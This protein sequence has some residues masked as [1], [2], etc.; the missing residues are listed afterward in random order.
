MSSEPILAESSVPRS[1]SILK[2]DLK[3]VQNFGPNGVKKVVV[4]FKREEDM[5]LLCLSNFLHDFVHDYNLSSMH[6]RVIKGDSYGLLQSLNIG[7]NNPV[8][9]IFQ[10]ESGSYG[11]PELY[12]D[13]KFEDVPAE[14]YSKS[15][16]YL[17]Y[18]NENAMEIPIQH[19]GKDVNAIRMKPE[20]LQIDGDGEQ[21][22]DDAIMTMED[23]SKKF[24]LKSDID[25]PLKTE[26][27]IA[28][29]IEEY[30]ESLT[31]PLNAAFTS[32]KIYLS[33]TSKFLGN[34]DFLGFYSSLNTFVVTYLGS[35][36]GEESPE[37]LSILNPELDVKSEEMR[38]LVM[39]NSILCS[40][41]CIASDLK[42]SSLNPGDIAME[43]SFFSEIFAILRLAFVSVFNKTNKEL[44]LDSLT[45]LNSD[46]VTQQFIIYYMLFLNCTGVEEFNNVLKKQTGGQ[47]G[48]EGEE[49]EETVPQPPYMVLDKTGPIEIRGYPDQDPEAYY[50]RPE[51]KIYLGTESIFITHNNLLTTIARGMFVKLGIWDKIF[52]GMEGYSKDGGDIYKF[53]YKEMDLI[54]YD[55]LMELYPNNPWN[56]AKPG[57]FNNELLI[58][59]ILILKNLLMEMSPSKTLT[60]GA[61]IDDQLKNYLDVFY[62][63][64]FVIK[65]QKTSKPPPKINDEALNNPDPNASIGPD[66]ESMFSGE[67]TIAEDENP[68]YSEEGDEDEE[69]FGGDGHGDGNGEIEMIELNKTHHINEIPQDPDV[70][71]PPEDSA[72][73][74]GQEEHVVE[75]TFSSFPDSEIV[76]P[77]RPPAMPI[78]FKNLKKMYQNNI[79]TMQNLQSSRIPAINIP[80]GSDVNTIYT[81]FELLT[82]NQTLMHKSGNQYNIPAPAFKFVINNAANIAANINGSKL[83]YTKR[84]KDEIQKVVDEVVAI[85]DFQEELE[86]ITEECDSI[87][88]EIA[89]LE[90]R[91]AAL[92]SLKRQNRIKIS[93]YNELLKTQF[94]IKTIRNTRLIPCENKK[95]LIERVVKLNNEELLK[96]E[97]W[98]K[99]WATNYKLWFDQCQPLFGL[100]RNLVRGTFCPT[101]SMMDAM[102]NCSLKYKA[103][104]PKEVG[105]THFELKYESES[106]NPETGAPDR[107]ISFGG[108][109]LNYNETIGSAEQLNAKIDFDLACIDASTGINDVA[110]ISTF[111]MQVAESHDLKASVVYK[112]II[113]KIKQI[114]SETYFMTVE[115]D[116]A[117]S[118]GVDIKNS[119]SRTTFLREKIDRM[120]SNMQIYRFEN[121]IMQYSPKNFNKLLTA[122]AIKTFGDFLQ[123]CLACM[124]WGGYVNSTDEFPD[125]VK[126]FISENGIDPIYRSV[127]EPDKIIPYDE[128]GNALR[129]GIQGDRPS[130]F[131]SI[132]I[133]LNGDSGVNQQ[134]IGGYI[135]TAANQKPSRSLLVS[136]ASADETNNNIRKDKLRGKVV[137]VTREL[138]IIQEDRIRYLK[139][140][141]YKKI[142]EKKNLL[143]KQT[144]EDFSPEVVG[145]IMQGSSSDA[146]YKLIKPPLEIASMDEPYKTS[147]YSEWDDYETPRVLTETKK[148]AVEDPETIAKL[149]AKAQKAAALSEEKERI[150]AEKTAERELRSLELQGMKAEETATNKFIKETGEL[151]EKRRLQARALNPTLSNDELLTKEEKG[152]LTRLQKKYP[153]PGGSRSISKKNIHVV[154]RRVSK[155]YRKFI[156]KTRRKNKINKKQNNTRR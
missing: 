66:T 148:K 13:S 59:Q 91:V 7:I 71:E 109:V 147:N 51:R 31:Y 72:L 60:F 63:H 86:K 30:A 37:F 94:D 108:V 38:N 52:S 74:E 95:Y 146:D 14:P 32:K 65:G 115:E 144:K 23:Y 139:S 90:L 105:T 68:E 8:F 22:E 76:D 112:S 127:S 103:S 155:K 120:W 47:D 133:L 10:Y 117:E 156:N 149:E 35:N 119:E 143:D 101:V 58:M 29:G 64:Y 141:Q 50:G 88:S 75:K 69:Q 73:A 98:L 28:T 110:N 135:F 53:G 93:E 79:Y 36:C 26:E 114:Y 82:Y 83:L 46:L 152:K 19:G 130:G 61:K 55:K 78:V 42:K 57:S 106:K 62:N 20:Q 70:A 3:A 123:E 96:G 67:N 85:A 81:L 21:S 80:F 128:H 9:K 24:K 102:F 43:Y 132:Y 1:Q 136:R 116:L 124:Q 12:D 16:S 137:Y 34:A 39:F 111:G 142:L 129:L 126:S 121:G 77:G 122:T 40:I 113:D 49:E 151:A 4:P 138:P 41:D 134:A 27:T 25:S 56:K 97:N 100:Y 92:S 131:R 48:E 125:R 11:D 6:K 45:I 140:L 54:S 15:H 87:I 99:E 84:D 118:A 5:I 104:E 44:K 107:V 145:P 17:E 33:L 18:F 154:K 89:P 150:K 2:V 153:F